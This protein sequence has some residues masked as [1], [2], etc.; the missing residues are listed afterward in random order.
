MNVDI[1]ERTCPCH[2][3]KMSSIPWEHECTVILFIGQNV[4][5]FVNDMFKLT[6]QQLVYSNIFRSIK[7]HDMSKVDDNKV[8][9]DVIG[10][11]F[12]FLKP[13]CT[14]RASG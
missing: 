13:P 5:D 1:V 14:K 6:T 9:R 10:N 11:V 8:V 4:V 12:F 3:W 7:T 2:C